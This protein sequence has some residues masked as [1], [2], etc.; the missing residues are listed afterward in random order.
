M[1]IVRVTGGLG[2]QMFQ[3]AMYKSLEKKGKLVKL[4]SKSFYETKKEHNGYELERIFDIK[5]NKP[6]KEDL[7]KFDEN[8]ISTLFKIKR[9]LFGDKKFVY[10]TKEYVFNK[11]VYKLKNSYL[12]GYWQSIKYFEGIEND[13]KKDFRF[14][15]QLDNKN[16]EILN[17]IENSNSISIHIR[18]GD[19][20]SPENYNMYGCIATPTYYKKAIKV[21]EEKVENPT[22]FVF[23]NDMDWV[24]KNIQI[25]SRVFYIDIN[26]GNG[27][28]KD[29][30]LMSN[31]KHNI[32][33]NSSFSW[34]GAW[35]NENKN[36]IVIAPKKW[37]NR[38]DVDSDKIELFCEG[39][40]LL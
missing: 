6:T 32:I 15:N 9:K 33:A 26:S 23:S 7:E 28:Y 10:D 12:N 27:S 13:I 18:R 34:W 22:F 35:L 39:W 20:M 25:N 21:I 30:Q 8:N 19:Y 5:P 38:E 37:I 4:D 16:L 24:K 3:Y 29:M 2:N 36:K 14:K 31:C 17:E 1:I 11:D 40:T